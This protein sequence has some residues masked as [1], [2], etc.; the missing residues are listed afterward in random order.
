MLGALIGTAVAYL[1]AAAYFHSQL[2]Q[3]LGHVPVADLGI[4]LIG[5]PAIAVVG[6]WLISGRE[7]SAIARQPIG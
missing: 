6:G 2:D 3:R 5:L 1:A 7:P 4:I